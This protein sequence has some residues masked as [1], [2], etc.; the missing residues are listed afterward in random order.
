[1]IPVFEQVDSLFEDQ[2]NKFW[3]NSKNESFFGQSSEEIEKY[4][5]F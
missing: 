2:G 3:G 4:I 5:T 1:M